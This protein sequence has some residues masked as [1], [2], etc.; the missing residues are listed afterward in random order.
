[1]KR[2]II[3]G[4]LSCS[5]FTIQAQEAVDLGEMDVSGN[6]E[7]KQEQT[8]AVAGYESFDPLDSGRSVIDKSTIAAGFEGGTDTTSLLQSLPFVQMDTERQAGTAEA[9]QSLRPSDFSISGG[10]FYDN[11]ILIDGVSATSIMDVSSKSKNDFNEVFGQTSQTLYVDPSLIGSIE[12]HDSNISARYGDFTGGVVDIKLREPARR[13]GLS[14]TASIQNDNFVSYRKSG[15]GEISKEKPE[16]TKYQSAL[17]L[18]L[19]ISDRLFFL[20]SISRAE[21]SV[22]YNMSENYG[23]RKFETGDRSSNYLLKALYEYSDTLTL[24]GQL[25]YSP[26]R[27]EHQPD[28]SINSL[29]LNRSN[30]LSSYVAAK[31][32]SGIASWQHKISY[33]ISDASRK[34]DGDRF[35]WPSKA[36][37]IDWCDSTNC[38][39]GGYGALDQTQQDVTYQFTF[40]RPFAGGDISLG[41]ELRYTL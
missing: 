41:S 22:S 28:N 20:A 7:S 24:D 29:N 36:P 34:W 25:V 15:F 35:Q 39:E 4:C 31:G 23:G 11:N 9:A 18:D 38:A 1:M 8:V 3:V 6:A 30:G 26:Y 12:V 32:V 40:D 10:N 37:S 16:F 17:S 33:Q 27:S 19:P 14:A 21:S 5:L 2:P 13:F